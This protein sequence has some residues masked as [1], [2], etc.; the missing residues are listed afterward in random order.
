MESDNEENKRDK[1]AVVSCE[2][3]G[4]MESK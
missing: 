2:F 4:F 1:E 3:D